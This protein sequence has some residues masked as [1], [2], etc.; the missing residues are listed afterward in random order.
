MTGR[1]SWDGEKLVMDDLGS[2]AFQTSPSVVIGTESGKSLEITLKGDKID[3]QGDAD[4]S[5]AAQVFFDEVCQCFN[6]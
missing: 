4:V 1:L 6:Q 5:E 2:L 3:I